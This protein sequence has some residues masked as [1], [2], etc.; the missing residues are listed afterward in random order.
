MKKRVVMGSGPGFSLVVGMPVKTSVSY[1]RVPG[2]YTLLGLLMPMMIVQ[3][4]VFLSPMWR[5]GLSYRLW[6]W[7]LPV[8]ME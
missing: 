2:F 1:V 6:L 3:L 5:F 8:V 7:A 4:I